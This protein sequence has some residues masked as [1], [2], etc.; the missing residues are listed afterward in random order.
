[1]YHSAHKRKQI[2]QFI[3]LCLYPFWWSCLCINNNRKYD[4]IP[5]TTNR[6]VL[7]T[8][9]WWWVFG[10]FE[11]KPM[12]VAFCCCRK[13]SPEITARRLRSAPPGEDQNR[14]GSIGPRSAFVCVWRTLRS[15]QTATVLYFLGIA[16]VCQ[17]IR[18]LL[19][20]KLL[21]LSN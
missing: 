1:M 19:L 20:G 17:R 6:N 8:Y 12:A 9:L 11:L 10:C 3:L 5:C 13:G 16:V 15:P 2:N 14:T 18:L 7:I 4:D 21:S